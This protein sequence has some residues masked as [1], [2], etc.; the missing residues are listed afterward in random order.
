MTRLIHLLP[1]LLLPVLT[2]AAAWAN[3]L[4]VTG[5]FA[6][7][8]MG[9]GLTPGVAYITIHGGSTADRLLSVT[10]PRAKHVALH[11]MMMQGDVMKM[12]EI[13]AIDVP[14]NADVKLAPG[15][16]HLMLEQL[17]APLKQGETVPLELRFEKAGTK[18]VEAPVR[19]PGATSADAK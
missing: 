13:D 19:A 18:S 5:A 8:S 6:R 3:D 12:R 2:P 11:S 10:S 15:G 1:A 16:L 4:S 9:S 7:A 14:A 17:T